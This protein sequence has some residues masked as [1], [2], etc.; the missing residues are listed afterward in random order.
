MFGLLRFCYSKSLSAS[1]PRL[2]AKELT[3]LVI[4]NSAL[5][6]KATFNEYCMVLICLI[7][8]SYIWTFPSHYLFSY[9]QAVFPYKFSPYTARS[10]DISTKCDLYVSIS[11]SSPG[12]NDYIASQKEW[13][14]RFH[15]LLYYY[16][17]HSSDTHAIRHFPLALCT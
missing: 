16:W 11:V 6:G 9:H 4:S 14:R 8:F 13:F 2:S 3:N 12:N 7:S 5:V 10:T 15:L 1:A 17:I